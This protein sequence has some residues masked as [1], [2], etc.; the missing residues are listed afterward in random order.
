MRLRKVF[1]VQVSHFR[2]MTSERLVEEAQIIKCRDNSWTYRSPGLLSST[3]LFSYPPWKAC[4]GCECS[5]FRG[6]KRV[7][8]NWKESGCSGKMFN[9]GLGHLGAGNTE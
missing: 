9:R 1:G 5:R 7:V 4:S 3:R 8:R 2:V 6:K